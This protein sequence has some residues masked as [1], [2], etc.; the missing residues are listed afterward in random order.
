MKGRKLVA[1]SRILNREF[2]VDVFEPRKQ[3]SLM[4]VMFGG[5]GIGTEKYEE[6]K[7][8][9]VP[10][11][12]E[13]LTELEREMSFQF[14]F[15]TAPY[16]IRFRDFGEF[17]DDS[18]IWKEH[19]NS[20][21]MP[22]LPDLPYYF[23]GYS[24]GFVLALNSLHMDE[25]CLGGGALGGDGISSDIEEGPSWREPLAFYYNLSD[26]VFSANREAIHDLEEAG[27]ARCFRKLPGGHDLRDYM[28]NQSFGGLIRRAFRI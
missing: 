12:D 7:R 23:I 17:E 14:V 3:P 21:I 16:D 15:I 2:H 1:W 8:V 18:R 9:L 28:K 11:F 20:E 10:V 26:K 4:I 25:D 13:A 27:I 22:K 24:G 19:V 6:R 5:S